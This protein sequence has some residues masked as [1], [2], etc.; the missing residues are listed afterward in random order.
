MTMT[1]NTSGPAAAPGAPSP[2]FNWLKALLIGSLALNLLFVGGAATRFFMHGP[3]ERFAGISQ[4]Q[5]IPRKFFG[6]LDRGR[7]NELLGIIREFGKE[8]RG[9]RKAVR[10]EAVN[11]AAALETEPYDPAKVK[12]VIDA[13]SERSSALAGKGGEVAL[14]V[15]G[16]LTP[17]ER[18]LLAKHI[19]LRGDGG[20]RGEKT[21]NDD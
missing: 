18:K 3:P 7:R 17:E 21:R 8:F 15:I 2:R 11:L 19:R 6:E 16:K 14:T 13:F 10:D 4:V 1:D 9:G 5:L 12:A 20:K